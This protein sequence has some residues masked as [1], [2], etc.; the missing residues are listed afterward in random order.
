MSRKIP[1]TFLTV[2]ILTYI[3]DAK[4]QNKK[5]QEIKIKEELF[6]GQKNA[7]G[8]QMFYLARS[9]KAVV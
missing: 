6:E 1:G 8:W 3:I 9:S 2:F 4:N 5:I 7:T